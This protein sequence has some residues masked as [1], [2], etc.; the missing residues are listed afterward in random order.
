MESKDAV[1]IESL[2]TATR[3]IQSLQDRDG[4]G[5]SDIASE[6]DMPVS[7]VHSYLSTLYKLQYLNKVNGE[8]HLGLRFLDHGTYARDRLDVYETAKE[9]LAN[10]A[11]KT[12]EMVYLMVEDNGKGVYLDEA[13]GEQAVETRGG[14]GKRSWLHSVA[15]G[16]A[17]LA[18]LDRDR[19]D[20]IID[21]YGLPARTE[22][23][24]TDRAEL[25]STLAEIREREYAINDHE[26]VLG[27]RAV[28]AAIVVEGEVYGAVSIGGPAKRFRGDKFEKELPNQVQ[29]ATNTIELELQY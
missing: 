8:Y 15:A 17:I 11:V 13:R 29:S 6:L 25:F 21:R 18:Y 4:T 27:I 9:T 24:I 2:R 28:G 22:H 12:G 14:I 20:D 23:T 26:D 7:T 10:F 1:E 19:V 5:A 3:I 16:K